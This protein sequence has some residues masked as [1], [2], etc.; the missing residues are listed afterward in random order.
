MNQ[1]ELVFQ[2]P[3]NAQG[4]PGEL[5]AFHEFT[6]QLKEI[7]SN[8]TVLQL[9]QTSRDP[10]NT[11]QIKQRFPVLI[12]E[13]LNSGLNIQVVGQAG[14]GKTTLVKAFGLKQLELGSNK[15][16]V[17]LPLS[18]LSSGSTILDAIYTKTRSYGL[19]RQRKEFDKALSKGDLLLLLDG[20]D[21]AI[22][23]VN[24]IQLQLTSIITSWP[25]TQIIVGTRHWSALECPSLISIN[26]L[27][28][29]KEQ[30]SIFF[31]NWFKDNEKHA[32]EIIEHF[33]KH[34]SL[35]KII[36]SPLLATVFAVIKMM[37]GNLPTSL[38]ELH[39]ERLR[40]MLHDWDSIKGVKRCKYSPVDKKFFLKKLAFY[41]H[42]NSKRTANY[43][44]L[45]Q[46]VLLHVGEVLD[47]NAALTFI[48]ELVKF[49]NLIFQDKDGAWSL[50]H[51]QFQEYLVAVEAKENPEIDL[52]L[53]IDDGWWD[54][55]IQFY[56]AVS[57]DISSLI[58]KTYKF[59]GDCLTD[60]IP[61][62]KKLL[63]LVSLAPNTNRKVRG[64]LEKEIDLIDGINRSFFSDNP[65]SVLQS[66]EWGNT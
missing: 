4:L 44:E 20:L 13:I 17:Y 37:G 42:K 10:E 7:L 46:I 19:F 31:R 11:P 3:A 28:F 5:K 9:C 49:N 15:S 51:L 56:A 48:D 65:S 30:L 6:T 26:L 64:L 61:I 24:D 14:A 27:L 59:H 45:I 60:K 32:I 23:R 41:L 25:K 40:L 38:V 54:L 52:S 21:E 58:L 53:Y 36:S 16:P 43:D 55:V 34:P 29:T 12:N 2:Q 8:E 62:L 63:S 33:D 18:S 1:N 47:K 66:F 35:Y 39:E 22:T 50:G 57:R